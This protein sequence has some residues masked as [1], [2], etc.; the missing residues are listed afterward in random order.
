M[1]R[2]DCECSVEIK[3]FQ[4]FL[5]RAKKKPNFMFGRNFKEKKK[6]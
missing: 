4:F 2:V 1:W 5:K 6:Q 3:N